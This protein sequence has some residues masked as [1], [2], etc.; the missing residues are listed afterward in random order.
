MCKVCNGQPRSNYTKPRIEGGK[1]AQERLERRITEPPF[2]WTGRI[3][4]RLQAIQNQ[5]A[6]TMRDQFRQPFALLPGRAEP[7]IRV[8]KPCESGIK[9]FIC[10]RSFPLLPCL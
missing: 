10:G 5:Q 3:L 1:L 6:P 7:W 4:E 9:K 2:L 8:A